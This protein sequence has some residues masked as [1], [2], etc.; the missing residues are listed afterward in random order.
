MHTVRETIRHLD[1]EKLGPKE[2]N[3]RLRSL[4]Y[5]ALEAVT[6]TAGPDIANRLR[7]IQLARSSLED[8]LAEVSLKHIIA[9]VQDSETSPP[10]KSH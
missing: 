5:A 8:G 1:L 3:A 4:I 2:K 6:S 7:H 10:P 9:A